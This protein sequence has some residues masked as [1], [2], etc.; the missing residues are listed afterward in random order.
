[1]NNNCAIKHPTNLKLCWRLCRC[2]AGDAVFGLAHGCLGTVVVTPAATLAPMP[3][4]LSFNEAATTPTVFITVEMALEKAAG[5]RPSDRVLVHAAAGGVGL[6]AIQ[7]VQARGATVIATAGGSAKRSLLHMLGAQ[8]VV[9]S[10]DTLFVSEVCQLGGADIVLNSLTS[11]GM[12][13]GSLA[14]LNRGGRFVEISKRDIWSGV[15]VAQGDYP[16]QNI[17]SLQWRR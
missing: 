11:A 2:I 6:A 9:G 14:A 1:M 5:M 13:A 12:V 7:A 16:S 15:R 3:P 10:R 17:L 4:M 8:H